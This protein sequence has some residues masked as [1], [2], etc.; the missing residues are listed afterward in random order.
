[1]KIITSLLVLFFLPSSLLISCTTEDLGPINDEKL[2]GIWHEDFLIEDN[3]QI[4][5][6]EYSFNTDNSYEV[7]RKRIDNNSGEILGYRYRELGNFSLRANTL[8]FTSIKRFNSDNTGQDEFSDI[9]NLQLV[10]PD[11][12]NTVSEKIEFRDNE[13]IL[14]FIPPPCPDN[15]ACIKPPLLERQ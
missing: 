4:S 2:L 3:N 9:E 14:A 12:Y 8:S 15:A 1:M 7:Q 13:K 6:L 10:S 11:F 5:R